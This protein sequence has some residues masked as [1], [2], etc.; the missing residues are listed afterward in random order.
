MRK[1]IGW[2][3]WANESRVADGSLF[4][5]IDERSLKTLKRLK[6]TELRLSILTSLA[7]GADRIVADVV[8]KISGSRPE[9]VLPMP[10][11]D[12]EKTFEVPDPGSKPDPVSNS[13]AE[14]KPDP[15]GEF[16]DILR[17]D[18]SPRV[19]GGA[20][21]TK[22][23]R[24]KAYFAA[25]K[26]IVD[27]C[28]VLIAVWNGEVKKGAGGTSDVIEYARG[29]DRPVDAEHPDRPRWRKPVMIIHLDK[30]LKVTPDVEATIALPG[31]AQL[32]A[33]NALPLPTQGELDE[34]EKELLE[35]EE[36]PSTNEVR[37]PAISGTPHGTA[38]KAH[39]LPL[40][41]QASKVAARCKGAHEWN[42]EAVYIMGVFAV[43]FVGFGWM[44]EVVGHAASMI[45]AA[46]LICI[47]CTILIAH[48]KKTH[49]HWLQ[50]RFLAER[51]RAAFYMQILGVRPNVTRPFDMLA[52]HDDDAW[53]VRVFEE[54]QGGLERAS[55]RPARDDG[56]L[57]QARQ[58][59]DVH[60]LD[61]QIKW[62]SRTAMK[63]EK[64]AKS[65]SYWLVG[66]FV[67]AL[68][69]A[70]VNV[71]THHGNFSAFGPGLALVAIMLP[72]IA[73]AIEG[74]RAQREFSRR[75]NVSKRMKAELEALKTRLNEVTDP[76]KFQSLLQE[77]DRSLMRESAEWL[78]LMIHTDVELKP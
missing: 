67:A 64:L 70:L 1:A 8:N 41:V 24:H 60:L 44:S 63:L 25:G 76:E 35:K 7:E 9:V 23:E 39:V 40:Y 17:R 12:Y 31:I 50:H 55:P 65:Y 45:E 3:A 54:V 38:V 47:L 28:D 18:P 69:T 75:A 77:V 32:D 56:W 43:L 78:A 15:V 42:G 14:A 29:F 30:E 61:G 52:E 13:E 2:E 27:R 46:L 72:V 21:A 4:A 57:E 48:W 6:H 34:K 71:L 68:V 22:E 20:P 49:R 53:V 11:A 33:F 74:V 59:I 73:G 5:L 66:A 10:A 26:Y 51:C 36:D 58:L 16:R 62:H 19:M 37:P